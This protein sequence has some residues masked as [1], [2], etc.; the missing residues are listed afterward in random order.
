M[1]HLVDGG[2]MYGGTG[3]PEAVVGGRARRVVGDQL[4]ETVG[5]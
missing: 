3:E 2:K 4:D 5:C 1:V